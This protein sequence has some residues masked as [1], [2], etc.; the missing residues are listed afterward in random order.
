[1]HKTT[2]VVDDMREK[3]MKK[4]WSHGTSLG[5]LGPLNRGDVILGFH[6]LQFLVIWGPYNNPGIGACQ[7]HAET[8]KLFPWQCECSTTLGST[9]MRQI[10]RSYHVRPQVHRVDWTYMPENLLFTYI[11]CSG[12]T[13]TT[14]TPAW[15]PWCEWKRLRR[16]I[17][18][19]F[20]GNLVL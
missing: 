14:T 1:M 12:P 5:S 7:G 11:V 4:F 18:N 9:T 15:L 8:L 17:A 20:W 3:N 6:R 19:Q 16:K 2:L 13:T 10:F